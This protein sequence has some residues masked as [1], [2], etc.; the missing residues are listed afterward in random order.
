M[1]ISRITEFFMKRPTLFWSAMVGILL[2]GVFSFFQMPKLEDP[3]ICVKQ[4]SVIVVY[5]GAS[6]YE[7][8]LK[9]AQLMEDNARTLPDV[10]EIR[11]ECQDGMLNM[12]VEFKETVLN[13]DLEQHF[14]QL[15][16]K[17]N[18]CAGAL[19]SACYSPIVVDDMTDT[20]G[21]FYALK[22]DGYTYNEMEKYAKL[23]RRELLSVDGVKRVNIVGT[24]REQIN[25]ILDKEAL[26][27]NGIIPTQMMMQLQSAG[28]TV[29]AG[30]Y[31]VD[32]Q[33]IQ[34]RVND[35][36][37][38]VDDV[39]NLL[40]ST[41][42][43]K[44]M[45]IGDLAK[46]ERSYVEPQTNGFWV[47]GV[48]S[49]AICIALENNVVVPDVGAAV[50]KKLA[51]TMNKIPAGL[52]TEKI[53]FQPDKVNEA[54][55]GFMVNLVES[56]LIVIIALIF[57]MGLRSGVIIGVGLILTIAVTFPFLQANG[58]TLQRISL[59]AFIIAM[60]MLVDNSIVIMD[61][62]LVDKQKKLGPKTYLYRIVDNTALPLLGATLIAVST[63]L[64]SYL[65]PDTAGEYCR[66][67]FL[68]MLF[69]LLSSW[70]LAMIQV[71][72]CAKAWMPVRVKN[73]QKS[74]DNKESKIQKFVR[75]L[76]T[77]LITYKKTAIIVGV[78]L[79]VLC[80]SGMSKVKNLFFPDFDYKQFVVEYYLP[81]QTSPDR[82]RHDLLQMTEELKKD[83]LIDRIAASM[84]CAP[85]H[86]CLVRP[87]TNGGDCYGELMI[88]CKDFETVNKVIAEIK[89]KLRAEYPDAYIR[90]KHYNF[91]VGSSHSLQA[92]FQGPDPAVLRK[93]AEQ[94][95]DIMRKSKYIDA[96]SVE[97]N[98][99]PKSKS[100][101]AKY[102]QQN[103]LRAGVNRGNVADALLAATD[104]LPIGVINDQDK[105]VPIELMI[106]NADGSKINDLQNIPVWSMMNINMSA[107]DVNGLMTGAKSA[108]D[109]K[110]KMFRSVP[111]SDA[112][113]GIDLKWEEQYVYRI[114]GQRTILAQADPNT[115]L[116]EGTTAKA[117]ADIKDAVESIPLPN[118]Y[119][120]EWSG[121]TKTQNSG[122]SNIY[123]YMPLVMG[124]VIITLLLLFGRW[125]QI[126]LVLCCFPF[127]FCGITP[128]LL[129]FRQPF[130]FMAIIGLMGLIGM[131]TKNAI[132][133][134][135][136]INRLIDEEHQDPFTALVDSSVSRARPVVMASLTT[137]L[138]MAPLLG[139]PMYGSMAI[140]IMSGLG[141]GTIVTLAF[142]PTIF[143]ALYGINAPKKK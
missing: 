137:I 48:P 21:L 20:Y 73:N 44:Q 18:D 132:V 55:N 6:A 62:I 135:D 36:M 13:K 33:R 77:V 22:S 17:V 107:D 86:Y 57:S 93:L 123:K 88:D 95:E 130:T 126:F 131:M 127:I 70:I 99:K 50:D 39:R 12:T 115:D 54:I 119:S 30:K 96:Y 38:T 79:L 102:E 42:S 82:V 108:N 63:F 59:G 85:A 84:G 106:R 133:L 122:T 46:V 56:V 142:L 121:E 90:F 81:A 72:I 141:V 65:S 37:T 9:V 76:C 124:I 97:N 4:A 89:P 34:L 103:A 60:G 31:E 15:R 3:A 140:V 129:L 52:T 120:F 91:S 24:R 139:D 136:N 69:S 28:K 8:E 5:P 2:I 7:V 92:Q 80:L 74:N 67:L 71:P 35:D 109:I 58:S 19:P 117:Q 78:A 138:G 114:N 112:T 111:L 25:I 125:K 1:K 113:N 40:I 47:D 53:F 134:I 14:D 87:M 49:L 45:R 75:K 128:A 105:Q 16:R 116:W 104:G 32:G 10:K 29:S 26:S 61:G 94:T 27:R 51:S 83:S 66:D 23:I 64:S 101:V 41:S 11:S 68:V 100:L 98:W 110:D 43:G 118:G 143:A